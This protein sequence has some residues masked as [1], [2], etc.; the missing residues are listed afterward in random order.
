MADL[1]DWR[2]M[3][4]V[5]KQLRDLGVADAL[6]EMGVKPGDAVHIGRAEL[7]MAL[8]WGQARSSGSRC[9]SD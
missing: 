3:I 4:Q 8:G 9:G 1:R 5:W 2:V 7:G 6:E